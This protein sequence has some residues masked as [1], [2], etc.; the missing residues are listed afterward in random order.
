MV[1]MRADRAPLQRVLMT[2]DCVGGVWSYVTD[3]A[4]ALKERGVDVTIALMGP[5]LSEAKREDARRRGLDVI[6]EAY[7]LEWMPA[8]WDD[9]DRAGEWLLSVAERVEPDLVHLNGFCHAALPWPT[10]VMVVGH[11]CVRTWWRGVHGSP[12][13]AE[14]DEYTAR[15]SEGL[16]AADLVVTPTKALLDDIQAE[17]GEVLRSQVIPNGSRAA[18]TVSPRRAKEPLVLS[19]GRLWDEAKNMAAICAAAADLSWPTFVAGDPVGP[20]G[21]FGGSGAVC[22]LGLLPPDQLERWYQRAAIYALPARYEPFG[23]SVVEAAAAG[24]ALVLGDIRTLRENWDGA[25]LFVPPDNRRA[26]ARAIESLIHDGD[27]RES[28]AARAQERSA[29]FTVD[30]MTDEYLEAYN[31]LLSPAA[32]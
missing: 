26:L 5:A 18:T 1:L 30:A 15:V 17:Y 27:R 9:V 31:A 19:A 20:T 25:A 13:P 3:L 29:R 12:A 11:S 22:C 32:A 28:L 21:T 4:S 2:A 24:C 6:A 7:R 16:S 23:L 8:P 10:P 14:W